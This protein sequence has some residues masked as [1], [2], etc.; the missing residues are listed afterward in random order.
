LLRTHVGTVLPLA[1][2]RE[3]HRMLEGQ[4]AHP[5]GKIVLRVRER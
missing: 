5:N 3:A 4:R 1:D 2:A